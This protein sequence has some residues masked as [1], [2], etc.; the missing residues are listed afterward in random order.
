MSKTEYESLSINKKVG[1]GEVCCI[2]EEDEKAFHKL[3]IILNGAKE[4]VKCPHCK[5]EIEGEYKHCEEIWFDIAAKIITF[6]LRRGI[7]EGT[8]ES[9]LIKHLINKTFKCKRYTP[10]RENICSCPDAIGE[11]VSKYCLMRDLI[12][13]PKK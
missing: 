10:N 8:I 1:C 13:P 4:F 3:R 11:S 7:W 12:K 6:G 9:G 2:F 5:K